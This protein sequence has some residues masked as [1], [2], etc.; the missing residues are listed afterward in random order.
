M[1]LERLYTPW[2]M[3]YINAKSKNGH[4]GSGCV[5]CDKIHSHQD[6][7]NFIVYRG[8]ETF[9]IL[10][11]Y[12]YNPGH[13]M[14]LPNAHVSTLTDLSPVVQAEIMHVSTYFTQV[15]SAVMKPDG[16]NVGLNL[17]RAAGAGIDAH[18]HMHVVPRWT[19]DSNFLPVLGETRILPEELTDTYDK[20][21]AYTLKH[22]LDLS[23]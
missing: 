17:G 3:K 18:L 4:G 7:E 21:K 5:F 8:P 2:R 11:I 19:G 23:I 16:F 1:T 22:P 12:P 10:N 20:L 6:R 9:A 14:V 13:L 15:I